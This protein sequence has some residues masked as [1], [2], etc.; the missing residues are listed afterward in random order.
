[1]V[2]QLL[3]RSVHHGNAVAHGMNEDSGNDSVSLVFQNS[4]VYVVLRG[5]I[6]PYC[7]SCA[8]MHH[9]L[10]A[11]TRCDGVVHCW[12]KRPVGSCRVERVPLC[13]LS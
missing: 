7:G 12:E 1:M 13:L 8:K 4:E 5:S 6:L 10:A 2:L 3:T 11:T 9:R